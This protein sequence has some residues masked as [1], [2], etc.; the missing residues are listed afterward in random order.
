MVTGVMETSG[1]G[2]QASL[3]AC[4]IG[5]NRGYLTLWGECASLAGAKVPG[6]PHLHKEAFQVLLDRTL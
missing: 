6:K 1:E 3:T 5:G 4:L 2:R